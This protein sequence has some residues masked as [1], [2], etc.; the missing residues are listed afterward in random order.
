LHS[1]KHMTKQINVP[2]KKKNIGG[3]R[4]SKKVATTSIKNEDTESI[5]TE[6]VPSTPPNIVLVP[7]DGEGSL[8]L[9]A[10]GAGSQGQKKV[11]RRKR[12]SEAAKLHLS[13]DELQNVQTEVFAKRSTRVPKLTLKVREGVEVS[14]AAGI[15]GGG[16]GNSKG[17]GGATGGG[18]GCGGAAPKVLLPMDTNTTLDV[19]S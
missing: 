16:Q 9:A 17:K 12:K 13:D 2:A 1:P 11:D 4:K 8:S 5:P 14:G 7:E 15:R 10:K 19:G 3:K 6:V 18:R